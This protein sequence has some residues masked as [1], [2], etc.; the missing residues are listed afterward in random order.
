V[1]LLDVDP[2]VGLARVGR[3]GAN[4][5]LEAESATFHERVRRA[6]LDLAEAEP[7]RYLVIDASGNADIIAEEI[8]AR[9][10]TLLPP[11]PPRRTPAEEQTV[12]TGDR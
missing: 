3:R 10:A 7:G 1:V 8:R 6:F 5:R 9:V 11:R 2:D 4:D 12:V